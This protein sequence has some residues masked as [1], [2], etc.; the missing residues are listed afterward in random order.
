MGVGQAE[1]EKVA[2]IGGEKL[3]DTLQSHGTRAGGEE[4]EV[5]RREM[6]GGRREMEGGRREREVGRREWVKAGRLER[7]KG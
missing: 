6:E 1:G 5:G 2:V 4:V 7:G 3:R